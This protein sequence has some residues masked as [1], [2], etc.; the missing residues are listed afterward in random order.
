MCTKHSSSLSSPGSRCQRCSGAYSDLPLQG[1]S[2]LT[3]HLSELA[4]GFLTGF[5]KALFLSS[6]GS[7]LP[8]STA[9]TLT[10]PGYYGISLNTRYLRRGS[11]EGLDFPAV[12]QQGRR[13]SVLS[14]TRQ[15]SNPLMLKCGCFETERCSSR[16]F[17]EIKSIVYSFI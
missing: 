13:C 5:S 4:A 9:Q 17:F 12:C 10:L 14:S 15:S 6:L 11:S 7:L 16:L 2:E 1:G 3:D 8:G